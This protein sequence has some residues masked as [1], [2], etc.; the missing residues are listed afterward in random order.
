MEKL[1]I[2]DLETTGLDY[3]IH[4]IHQLSGMIVIDG[5]PSPR[6]NFNFKI[7]PYPDNAIDE[8]ALKVAGVTYEQIVNYSRP[9]LVYND[10]IEILGKFVSKFDKKDKFHLV[11]YNNSSFD[12]QFLRQFWLRNSD[13]YFGSWFWSDTIDIMSLASNKLR[14]ERNSMVNFKLQTVAEKLGVEVDSGKLHDATY[15]IQ[16]TWEIFK[17]LNK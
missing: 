16:L 14:A 3:K 2:Y 11:G 13:L 15:D 1:F 8:E 9:R 10:L 17:I 12:N 7:A 4:G 6:L 5:E